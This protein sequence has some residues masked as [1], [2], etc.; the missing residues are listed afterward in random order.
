VPQE[1]VHTASRVRLRLRRPAGD[2]AGDGVPVVLVEGELDLDTVPELDRF[3]RRRLGPFYERQHLLLD[4][5]G[6]TF[7][8]SSFVG[9]L[10]RL[11]SAQRKARSELILTRPVG[12]VRTVLSLV[13]LPN[14]VPVFETIEEGE[15]AMTQQG[16]LIPPLFSPSR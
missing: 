4:L 3:L 11:V 6:V 13:G 1:P 8:D 14:L 12:Q 9:F 2:G 5:K 7:A 10:V 16:P 15:R